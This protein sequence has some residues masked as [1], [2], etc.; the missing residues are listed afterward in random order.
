[1]ANN[2]TLAGKYLC[3]KLNF[4]STFFTKSDENRGNSY[5]SPDFMG[6]IHETSCVPKFTRQTAHR[7]IHAHRA[8]HYARRQPRAARRAPAQGR[9]R[10][11]DLRALCMRSPRHVLKGVY[12]VNHRQVHVHTYTQGHM[13][14]EPAT[15]TEGLAELAYTS[16]S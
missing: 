7:H 2:G 14:H 1:M 11:K 13:G 6:H 10:V 9:I 8:A 3:K 4:F 5:F 16:F 12:E 15:K